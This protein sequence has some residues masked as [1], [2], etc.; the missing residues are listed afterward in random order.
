M[1]NSPKPAKSSESIFDK[2]RLM[3]ECPLCGHGYE[4]DKVNLLEE[5]ADSHLVH[6]TCGRCQNA[7]L[8]MIVLSPIGISSVGMVTDLTARDVVRLRS[9]LPISEDDLLG[10]HELLHRPYQLENLFVKK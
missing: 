5:R 8:A 1:Q 4:E 2:L 3:Q 6:I 7:I 9:K 10:F